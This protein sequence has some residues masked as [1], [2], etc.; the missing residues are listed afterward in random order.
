MADV[1]AGLEQEESPAGRGNGSGCCFRALSA[2]ANLPP[3]AA[4]PLTLRRVLRAGTILRSS[5]FAGLCAVS[6][7]VLRPLFLITGTIAWAM[8]LALAILLFALHLT[9]TLASHKL[10]RQIANAQKESCCSE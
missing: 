3:T 1:G 7:T 9:L 10:S 4:T 2:Q 6:G 8:L 5:P